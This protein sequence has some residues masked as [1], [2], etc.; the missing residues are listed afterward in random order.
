MIP[1]LYRFRSAE[2]ILNKY[3]ELERGEIYFPSTQ[4]LN[5]PMEG[6]KDLYWSGD[7]IVW[8]NCLKHYVLCLLL[9]VPLAVGSNP[10]L[11]EDDVRL[12]VFNTPSGFPFGHITLALYRAVYEDF[13]SDKRIDAFLDSLSARKTPIR[14]SELTAYLR[15]MHPYAISVITRRLA[16][17]GVSQISGADVPLDNLAKFLELAA[18]DAAK[19]EE[20]FS[21]S[22]LADME[23][24]LM[25][26][27]SSKIPPEAKAW[28]FLVRSFPAAYANALDGLVHP[29][30]Y[31][32]CFVANPTDASMWGT[33][34]DGH[35]GVCLKFKTSPDS[36]G[37]PALALNTPVGMGGDMKIFYQ[38]VPHAF[39]KVSY[40]QEYP[41][42]DFFRSIGRLPTPKLNACW[43]VDENGA[44]SSCLN[45]IRSDE[46]AWRA[47]YWQAFH[48]GA[49]Q[50]TGEWAHEE[51]YRLVY[52][53][54]GFDLREKSSR[55]LRYRFSDLSGIIFGMQTSAENKE[56][57]LRTIGD[58][59]K[60]ESRRD[61]E[62][63]QLQYS[64]A[65]RRFKLVLLSSLRV[66]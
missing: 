39:W 48:S 26:A 38:Y 29:P 53:S 66:N 4:E 43:Y 6:Y 45:D 50:K 8:R 63:Y 37:R 61:F 25:H 21:I 27:Y 3:H 32:A 55:K 51:E 22:D 30:G 58:K 13:L 10:K 18:S 59:C 57:I 20:F 7:R 9:S 64:R 35:R 56:Q 44:R 40:S 54:D 42:I 33:Y 34:G 17:A 47:Q 5:D 12:L 65:G 28:E 24:S 23:A 41:E 16:P 52:S 14:R 36:S 2:A 31:A 11:D 1:Y 62:F 60:A 46:A 49:I 19:A 15:T